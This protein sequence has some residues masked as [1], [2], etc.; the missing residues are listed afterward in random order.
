MLKIRTKIEVGLISILLL[1]VSLSNVLSVNRTISDTQDTI[2]T[3][4]R[5]SNGNYWTATGANIQ[6]AI[7]DLNDT[8]GTV[9]LPSNT[10][11]ISVGLVCNQNIKLTGGIGSII[12]AEAN[13]DL[14]YLITFQT[15]V[16][17]HSVVSHITLD[18]NRDS[19]NS[20]ITGILAQAGTPD[21][22]IMWFEIINNRI[23]NCSIGIGLFGYSSEIWE[24]IWHV[25]I[26]HNSFGGSG[27]PNTKHINATW[28]YS[29]LV[30]DNGFEDADDIG[31]HLYDCRGWQI[32]GNWFDDITNYGI[33]TE[34]SL[35]EWEFNT[36]I[37][38][39]IFTDAGAIYDGI[40]L[41]G[42]VSKVTVQSNSIWSCGRDGIM[43]LDRYN[44]IDGNHIISN[45]GNGIN[46]TT[47]AKFLII[48]DNE[49]ISNVDGINSNVGNT[50]DIITGNI[51]YA[52]S[53]KGLNFLGS[54]ST[55]ANNIFYANTDGVSITNTNGITSDNIGY[56]NASLFPYY[57]QAIPP[58]LLQN[59]TAYWYNTTS[60]Y[61]YSVSNTYGTQ[62]YLNWSITY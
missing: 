1:V 3:F 45:M 6:T 10:I 12:K 47:D 49:I 62:R 14:N 22:E 35:G 38:D 51:I 15:D 11:E 40:Y 33:Y 27:Y 25:K 56:N 8:G 46:C 13:A 7:W 42:G 28:A 23:I 61:F 31:I 59:T 39:N 30:K 58:T 60:T 37:S 41:G 2:A 36:I 26:L 9:Y 20:N 57:A 29:I 24:R 18:G 21:K 44:I 54:Y 32:N 48:T 19:G 52:N 53:G 17:L 5:N 43:V 16:S 55:I 34:S 50:Y 4:V